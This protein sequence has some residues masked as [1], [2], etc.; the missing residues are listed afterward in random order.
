[1]KNNPQN[2]GSGEEK[3]RFYR[4][5]ARVSAIGLE[6][7]LAVVIGL[8][9]GYLLDRVFGTKPWLMV[10]FLILGVVA[11]FRSLFSL[12]KDIDKTERKK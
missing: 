5:F 10:V 8:G 4:Q 12:A 3:R 9:I 6:M 7:G 2:P 11:A 1:M